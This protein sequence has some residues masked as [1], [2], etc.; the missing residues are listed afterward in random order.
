M[1]KSMNIFLKVSRPVILLHIIGNPP[2]TRK[3][4]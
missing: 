2:K 4:I 3:F 1:R